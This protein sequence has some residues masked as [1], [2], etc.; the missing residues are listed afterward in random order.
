M[1]AQGLT[2]RLS[3]R[4]A[5]FKPDMLVVDMLDINAH[6]LDAL[7]KITSTLGLNEFIEEVF[8]E[9]ATTFTVNKVYDIVISETMLACLKS[10]PQVAIMQ[11]LIPQ[12]N[13]NCVFIPQ[14]IT[15]DAI[16]VNPKMEQDRMLYVIG[17][18]PAFERYPLGNVITVSKQNMH[19]ILEKQTFSIA[20]KAAASFPLLKL[21]TTVKVYNNELLTENDS[22][23]TLPKQLCDLRIDQ[24]Q[25]VDFWYV[26]GDKPHIA[27]SLA[28]VKH[29]TDII[30]K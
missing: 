7:A 30:T 21:F 3:F 23:I 6:S 4:K 2:E 5:L 18:K 20:P 11:N 24:K 1:P 17:E 22:S 15:V 10:E 27:C 28:P 12:L 13:K 29:T 14:E 16:L 8:C 25:E 9:D 26:Q 19:S